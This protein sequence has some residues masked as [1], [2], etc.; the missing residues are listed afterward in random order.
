MQEFQP[1][2]ST[3]TKK[4]KLVGLFICTLCMF[5][6]VA[7]TLDSLLYYNSPIYEYKFEKLLQLNYTYPLNYSRHVIHF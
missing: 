4:E 3:F 5:I 2:K 7:L 6:C 1:I